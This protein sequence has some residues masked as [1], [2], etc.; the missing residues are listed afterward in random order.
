MG[1]CC[2]TSIAR[3]RLNGWKCYYSSIA[4]F[5]LLGP[6][7]SPR[8]AL[9]CSG[10]CGSCGVSAQPTGAGCSSPPPL[11]KPKE[12]RPQRHAELG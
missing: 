6:L 11:A 1:G 4:A 8:T 7:S 5:H 10:G 9:A 12:R 3:Q 2:P